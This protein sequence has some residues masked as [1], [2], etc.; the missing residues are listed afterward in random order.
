MK[1]ILIV[2]FI[3]LTITLQAQHTITGTVVNKNN[4]P[5]MGV[6][7]YF[8]ELQKGTLTNEHGYYEISNLP[9]TPIKILIAFMGYKTQTKIITLQKPLTELNFEMQESVFSMEEV[10]I[11]TPFNKLQSENVIKVDKFSVEQ[12][13]NKG[14]ITLIEGINSISG[15]SQ[16]STGTG[17]GKPVI[18]GLRGNRVLV[19]AQNIRLENQQFG[20]EHGLG[21]DESSIESIEVIKGPAS[22]L[23]GSDALG[24]V[25]YFIPTK[26]AE[27]N[28][29]KA[30]ITQKYFTNT[31]GS[32]TSFGIKQS[33][34]KW[35]FLANG[36]YNTQSD[37]KTS[38]NKRVTNSRFNET[39]FNTA[40]GFTNKLLT[41]S[42]RF[43]FNATN[44]G[45]PEEIGLQNTNKNMLLPYQELSNKMLS[46]QNTFFINN[47]K[48]VTVLGYTFNDRKEFEDEND[49]MD[50]TILA[51]ALH[52]KLK[53]LSY[54]AKW[55]LPALKNFE[56]ILGVQGLSQE[57]KNLGEEILIPSA[58][59]YDFGIFVT[60][61]NSWKNNTVQGG[62]RFDTRTIQSEQF[63]IEDDLEIHTFEAVNKTYKN[64]TASL[65]IKTE[66]FSKI[67]SRVNL[68]SGFRAPNLA[69][70]TSN[71]VHN[72]T[73]RYE[74]GNPNL[75]SEQNF[76]S[77]IS[78]EYQSKHFEVFANGFYNSINNYIF[79]SPTGAMEG[80]NFV[81]QYTQE[82]AN[83]YG[84][85]IGLHVHPHPL[86]WLHVNSNFEFVVGEQK[87]GDYLPL[88]PANKLT[89][90]LKTEFNSNNTF[91]NNFAS[92]TVES[93]FK[94]DKVSAF[95]TPTPSYTLVNFGMGS[96]INLKGTNAII[97]L[98]LNNAFNKSYI[99]H[100]SRLKVD[101]IENIG[102]NFV[103]SVKFE[104]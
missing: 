96:T 57:N 90:T 49:A 81:Y 43:N 31:L 70:L 79:I 21:V 69:E 19:Y 63:S 7:V 83:L 73:N 99:S 3:G 101:N 15:V 92:I 24:G 64:L 82:N 39:I 16:V 74:I 88:I 14:A 56:T 34:N 104:L 10:I 95:E 51:P 97:N 91:K 59:T 41:S 11:A 47:S 36:S 18:R 80:T 77:D 84:G 62:I 4:E 85:E 1:S 98:N 60:A 76:Q 9:G 33:Y 75:K 58:N 6:E 32:T 50:T 12:L 100:L 68:A 44:V 45:I 102:R 87:N 89:N 5:L 17:I 46:F 53:T 2:L 71:G 86:D 30:N 66:L 42:L 37:Y 13:Q 35:K 103:V 26:F 67:I 55:Y 61:S 38:K 54:D 65:G 23:Y 29:L 78:F 25:L 72:G 52:L 93:T 22:L 48:L 27:T 94:Q 28:T 40:I 8:E 20:D